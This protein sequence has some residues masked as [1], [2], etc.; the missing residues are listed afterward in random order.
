MSALGDMGYTP[1]TLELAQRYG[2]ILVE[3]HVEDELAVEWADGPCHCDGPELCETC[4]ARRMLG[5]GVHNG[6]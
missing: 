1:V 6:W 2:Q 4:T 5:L 3:D